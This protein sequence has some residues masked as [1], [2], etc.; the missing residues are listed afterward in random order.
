MEVTYAAVK[1]VEPLYHAESTNATNESILKVALDHGKTAG[2]I[3]RMTELL[4]SRKLATICG[5]DH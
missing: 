3:K 5:E 2:V 1:I 4:F